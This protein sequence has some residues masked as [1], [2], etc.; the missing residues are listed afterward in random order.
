MALKPTIYKLNIDLSNTDSH[1]YETLN[2]TIALH[3]SENA[4]R[5]MARV[6]AYCI[7]AKAKPVFSKGL[8]EADE[9]AIWSH[10]L[11]GQLLLWIDVGEPAAERIKKATHLAPTTRI[12]SFNSKSDVWWS[13]LGKDC[14][15]LNVEVFRFDHEAI[16]TM[17]QLLQRTMDMA[18]IISDN[19]AYISAAG[20]E[21]QVGWV[22]LQGE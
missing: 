8:S 13:Q 9:P 17:A 18:V 14:E 22:C 10:S 5:M 6:L 20:G 16:T 11:D 3:P 19:S 12:Y 1:H 4:T 15:K 7:N 2:L 21:C